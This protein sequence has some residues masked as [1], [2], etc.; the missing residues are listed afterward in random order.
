MQFRQPAPLEKAKAELSDTELAD[1]QVAARHIAQVISQWTGIPVDKM[2]AG[3]QGHL[4]AMEAILAQCV[5]GQTEVIAAY[6]T[7]SDVPSR[8]ER[9]EP[10]YGQLSVPWSNR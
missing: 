5:V 1:E 3:E 4:L 10:A 8:F 2:T 9:P 6:Q 7:L